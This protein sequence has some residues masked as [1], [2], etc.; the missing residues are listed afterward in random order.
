[1]KHKQIKNSFFIVLTHALQIPT[2]QKMQTQHEQ[3]H[4]HPAN[5]S[6]YRNASYAA[7]A[8]V[9]P[10]A[11]GTLRMQHKPCTS[12]L[13]SLLFLCHFE[14]LEWPES[15]FVWLLA[16]SAACWALW[17]F[18]FGTVVQSHFSPYCAVSYFRQSDASGFL[19]EVALEL[20]VLSFIYLQS[21]RRTFKT[22]PS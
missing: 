19:Q 3:T 15:S 11:A 12:L 9:F 22:F 13:N 20:K 8:M 1:M 18:I 17:P 14:I 6:K 7:A 4:E 10:G 2:T 5:T 21:P 16:A